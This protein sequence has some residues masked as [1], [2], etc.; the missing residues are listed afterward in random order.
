[1]LDIHKTKIPVAFSNRDFGFI[2]T[3]LLFVYHYCPTKFYRGAI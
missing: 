1:M 2:D 3:V